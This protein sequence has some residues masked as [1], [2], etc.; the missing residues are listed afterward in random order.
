MKKAFYTSYRIIDAMGEL[1]NKPYFDNP[2]CTPKCR[3]EC[4]S[5]VKAG[6]DVPCFD[7]CHAVTVE[8]KRVPKGERE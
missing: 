6:E 7:D 3:R 5:D 4:E 2:F 1:S 8:V